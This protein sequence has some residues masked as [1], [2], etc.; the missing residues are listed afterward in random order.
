MWFV[1]K[2]QPG[3]CGGGSSATP[4]KLEFLPSFKLG[5]SVSIT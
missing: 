1:P 2:K 3:A 5:I 4:R